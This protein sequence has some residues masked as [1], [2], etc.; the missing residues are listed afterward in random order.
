V[1]VLISL[2]VVKTVILWAAYT[3]EEDFR[4]SGSKT[5]EFQLNLHD[6][7]LKT[8][9]MKGEGYANQGAIC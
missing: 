6:K 3:K 2:V 5:D 7:D 9:H 4:Q 8:V 1:N